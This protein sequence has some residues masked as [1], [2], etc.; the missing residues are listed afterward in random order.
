[1]SR[2]ILVVLA[3]VVFT[4]CDNGIEAAK[5]AVE[6][7]L[8]HKQMVE[9]SDLEQYPGKVVC[10][11]INAA[12]AWGEGAGYK[13]FVVIDGQAETDPSADD[14]AIFCS[15]DSAAA[16]LTTLGIGP[17]DQSNPNLLLVQKHLNELH[18]ALQRY[19][20]D[21][22]TYPSTKAGLQ[23]LLAA[24][25]AK[26][27]ADAQAYIETIP[28]DPWGRPYHYKHKRQLHGTVKKYNLYTLGKDGVEGGQGDNADISNLHLKY[29]NHIADL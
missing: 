15:Q 22:T 29:L 25:A 2:Y 4:G 11:R 27:K 13:P 23:S 26:Q 9:Y 28:V 6:A 17:M 12:G 3:L 24:N 21:N 14:L 1:M 8:V 10:G 20:A 16:L 5:T 19:L 18:G 7:Q